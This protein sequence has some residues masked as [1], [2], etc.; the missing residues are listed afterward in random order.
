MAKEKTKAELEE[1]VA[2][3]E[4]EN[5]SLKKKI[6]AKEAYAKSQKGKAIVSSKAV[7]H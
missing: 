3:L 5:A 1:E 6:A 2:E 4:K 7:Q